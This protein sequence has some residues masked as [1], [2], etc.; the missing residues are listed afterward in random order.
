MTTRVGVVV[1]PGSNCEYD[2][3]KALSDL[4]A[5]AAFIWHTT[6]E[7]NEYDAIVLP[8]GFAHGDYLRPGA[9]ARFSPVMDAVRL[10]ASSGGP[11][12]GIC[13]GF[14]VL[15]EAG[16][17]PGALQKNKGLTFLSHP[18]T[19]VVVSTR[20]VLTREAKIGQELSIPIN[21]FSG[22]YTCDDAT[23]EELVARDQIVMRYL[24]N[25]NGSRDDI[26]AVSNVAGNV[27]G[28]MPHP[29]RAISS[30][31]GSEDGRPLLRSLLAAASARVSL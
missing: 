18:A 14:Q 8:G 6:T 7:I 15:T 5:E 21:H 16:L 12:L 10:F 19:V 4:G 11:V 3:L 30:L 26:A 22:S 9:I 2:A 13:N 24:N 31:L 29:E 28:L 20:S 17:L 27:V 23:Y 1:F 25:P